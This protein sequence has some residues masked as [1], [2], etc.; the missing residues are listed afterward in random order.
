[1]SNSLSFLLGAG[2]SAPMGY[3]I[4]NQ[5]NDLL[6][7]C[8][9]NDFSFHTNGSLIPPK[10]GQKINL[11]PKTSYDFEYDFCRDLMHYFNDKKGYFD[12]EEFYDFFMDEAKNNSEVKELFKNN[13]YRTRRDLDQMLS[14]IRNIFSQLVS[15]FLVDKDGNSWYDSAGHMGKPIF[16]GYTGILNCLEKFG[17]ENEVNIHTLNHDLF[18]ERLAKTDWLNNELSDGFDDLGSPYYGQL[19]IENRDYKCRL[20]R[21]TGNYPK[22]IKLYKLHGSKDYATY[23]GIDVDRGIRVPEIYLKTRWGIGFSDFYKEIKNKEGHLFYD[24]GGFD[25]HADFLTGTT[26]KIE[27]YSE[28]LFFNK[29][30]KKFKE[31]LEKTNMLIIVGYGCRD[32]GINKIIVENFD[33]QNKPSVII[34]PY[35]GK[36]VIVL[37]DKLGSRLVT[38]ELEKIEMSDL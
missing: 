13:N 23:Y 24:R 28:P 27:R 11:G 35:A 2:F 19:T 36:E 32:K 37:K 38:K 6:L 30:F 1:M 4:G 8:D 17:L 7:K 31:N 34:D 12:Y 29:L 10:N 3:P 14:A 22:K 21:Y 16:T 26:S 25:F 15:H 33:Y 20:Q 9:G 5:L 18:F